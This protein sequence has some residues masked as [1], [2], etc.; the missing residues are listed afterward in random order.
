M[1]SIKLGY[2]SLADYSPKTPLFETWMRDDPEYQTEIRSCPDNEIILPSNKAYTI[3]IDYPLTN[4]FVTKV[5]TGKNGLTRRQVVTKICGFYRK[6]YDD[7]A[8]S[9][10]GDEKY[11]EGMYNRAKSN[12]K[13]GIWGHVISDL[14][15]HSLEVSGNK[16]GVGVDS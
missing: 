8:A 11:I 5:E 1:K 15:L 6:I 14:M 2:I 10:D 12:G 3:K 4:A 7:E 16:L 9:M 13:Y